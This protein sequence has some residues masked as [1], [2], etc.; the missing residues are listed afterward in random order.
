[1][2]NK[3]KYTWKI[4]SCEKKQDIIHL[5]LKLYA[6]LKSCHKFASFAKTHKEIP[7]NEHVQ[8]LKISA[9]FALKNTY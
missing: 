1:M 4:L 3:L 5:F 2:D 9:A 8:S 7:Q 6:A